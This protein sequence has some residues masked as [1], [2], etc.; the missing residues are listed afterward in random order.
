MHRRVRKI[1]NQQFL[2]LT[3][4]PIYLES[5]FRYRLLGP[6][7]GFFNLGCL[8]WGQRV[9]VSNKLPTDSNSVSSGTVLWERPAVLSLGSQWN[10]Q[11][12][13]QLLNAWVSSLESVLISLVSKLDIRDFEHLYFKNFKLTE[14]LQLRYK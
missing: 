4:N 3:M 5:L 11:E 14:K 9:C 6:T 2:N 7:L 10:H 1:L 8:E 13:Q 12:F